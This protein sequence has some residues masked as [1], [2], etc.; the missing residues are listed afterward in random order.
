MLPESFWS[1]FFFETASS[2]PCHVLCY[3]PFRG[4][5]RIPVWTVVLLVGAAQFT[6]SFLYAFQ[7]LSG[8]D[9][10]QAEYLYAAVCI[11]IYFLSIRANPWKLLFLYIFIFDYVVIIRGSSM[12]LEARLFYDPALTFASVRS[13]LLVLAIFACT[14]P[15]MVT[16]LNRTRIRIFQTDAPYFWR[17]V[18]LLPAFNTAIV[19]MF[20]SDLTVDS[21]W[22]LRFFISRVFLIAG[23][24]LI[25]SNFLHTLD[26]VR[27]EA[28][29][30]EQAAQQETLLAMQNTQYSQLSRHIQETRQ[31]RHDLKQHLKLINNYLA[32]GS[33]EA[34]REYVET[35]T[36][37]LPSVAGRTF[38]KNYAVNTL[39][40][41]YEEEAQK[42]DIRFSVTLHLPEHLPVPEPDFCAIL[43]NL[44][45]NALAACQEP[46]TASP[47]IHVRGESENGR[48]VL[49]VRNA[50]THEPQMKNGRFLSTSH[51][52]YGTGTSSI[53]TIAARY[54]GQADFRCGDHTFSSS[55]LL[56]GSPQG[57]DP[58]KKV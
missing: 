46:G 10:R 13:G 35:Y 31:A 9:A 21:V 5:F 11:A 2:L 49:S 23:T 43:G 44:M 51:K 16:F 40:S 1:L 27:H 54:E 20:T 42:T 38:C 8:S 56:F 53:R 36:R 25:Y 28:V 29:L 22:Q 37:S 19:M 52:G 57:S 47:F 55:V 3:Y 41:Y 30:S 34:L 39:L 7:T 48:I 45:E 32:T 33:Q 14:I 12:F 18:W 50:C 17:R 58:G 6:Q 4:R 26:V 15:F 24:I